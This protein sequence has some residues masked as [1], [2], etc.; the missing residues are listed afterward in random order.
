MEDIYIVG[1][2]MTPFGRML[3]VD[4]KTMTR[5]AIEAALADAGHRQVRG[6]TRPIS[7][8]RRR[9]TWKRQ[10]MIRGEIALR[11]MGIGGIP[12][13]NVENACASGSIGLQPR[14]ELRCKAGAVRHRAGRRRREDV[15]AGPRQMFAVFDSG[16]DV[17]TRGAERRRAA[18]DGRGRRGAA[19]HHVR[20]ALQRVHGRLR[21]VLPLPHEA[22]RH[23][24]ARRSPRSPP[25]TTS[26]RC[27]IRCRSTAMPSRIEEVLAA[28]PITYPL[29]LP[30][31][32]PISRRR[33][34]RGAVQRRARSRA[35][36]SI[37]RRA[38]SA[39]WPR[40]VQTGSDREPDEVEKHVH[41]AG[42]ASAPTT[43]AGVG[44]SDVV[45][46]R[47]A[48]RH[49]DGR[50]HPARESRLLRLRR[51]RRHLPSAARRA[52]AAACRSIRR[53]GWNPRA[54]RSARPASAR[55]TSW[56]TQLRGEAGPAPG[57]RRAHRAWPRTAAASTASRKRWP[58][59]RCSAAE[60]GPDGRGAGTPRA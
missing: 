16:W 46:G 25:R 28:P 22:L 40:V 35:S 11:S 33:G 12:V 37:A 34:G 60:A 48:R 32:S 29:T 43:S 39:C 59:S 4:I 31:C 5:K 23:D 50:D 54:I 41:R 9:A 8:T 27:T 49:R 42:G 14:G 51:R 2:G 3:D 20:Q 38:R 57:R 10:H 15:L 7:P 56:S 13:V 17:T 21:G 19:G 55:S 52:S 18:G 6:S 44:P 36:A 30:M 58:A 1:V 47:S 24:A 53:A 26:T 45:G